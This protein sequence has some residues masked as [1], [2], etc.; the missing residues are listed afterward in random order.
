MN[1]KKL[2]FFDIDGT[3]ITEGKNPYIPESTT[4]ALEL[5]RANGHICIINTGRPYA[6][7]DDLIK[8][9]KVDGYVCGCGTY[10]KI[11]DEILFSYHLEK[12]LCR[13]MVLELDKCNAEWMLEG[14]K[15]V[16]YSDKTYNSVVVGEII[17]GL[18]DKITDRMH[19]ISNNEYSNIQ[20]EKLIM[21][22]DNDSD[23][24]KF[25]SQF[26]D[27][28]TFIDR[29][30][31]FFEVIPKSYSKATG[32][33]FLEKHFGIDHKNTF[34]VGDSSNDIPMLEYAANGIL[35]GGADEKLHKYANYVTTSIE[36]DG[37]YNA[38]KHF[39]LI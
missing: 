6:S 5:L 24:E 32:M 23:F 18:K 39:G 31:E 8:S 16:Y 35:M 21:A 2:I 15:A 20:F 25:H 4:K 27:D 26:K 19:K 34:A 12:S 1:D 9:I 33:Q 7:L 14:E 28:F 29:G 3:L 11:G 22:V 13:K 17:E 10:I 30:G 36:N 38:F 37:I